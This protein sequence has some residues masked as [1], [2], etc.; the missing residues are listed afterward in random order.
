ME[1]TLPIHATR[2]RQREGASLGP[3]WKRPRVFLAW[4]RFGLTLLPFVM[5][6][7]PTASRNRPAETTSSRIL[8]TSIP[9]CQ[10]T[11]RTLAFPFLRGH[12]FSPTIGPASESVAVI[13]ET[14]ARRFSSI[15]I[16]WQQLKIPGHIHDCRYCRRSKETA[17]L[18]WKAV[19]RVYFSGGTDANFLFFAG[20]PQSP[21]REQ[22]RRIRPAHVGRTTRRARHNVISLQTFVDR[23]SGR[24]ASL[25]SIMSVFAGAGIAL[26]RWASSAY[27]RIWSPAAAGNRN[28]DGGR[29]ERQ[30]DLP[31]S[32]AGAE[33]R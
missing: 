2:T 30:G 8:P 6:R 27:F 20:D 24:D 1:I 19:R 32:C 17:L 3:C 28:Q 31:Y 10:A 12:I 14:L 16:Y 5:A 29:C 9:C 11:S 22:N 4:K 23:S 15:W 13:D 18:T 33:C 7:K 25:A 21:S 26:P